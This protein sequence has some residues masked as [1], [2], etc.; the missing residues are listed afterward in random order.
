M[1]APPATRARVIGSPS[2]IAAIAR[3]QGGSTVE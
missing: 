1:S 3:V 2:S